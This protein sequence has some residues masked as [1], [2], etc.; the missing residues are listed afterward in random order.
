MDGHNGMLE[1]RLAEIYAQF[2]HMAKGCQLNV[3]GLI[4][5]LVGACNTRGNQW[6][7]V[8]ATGAAVQVGDQVGGCVLR[9]GW[10]R[11]TDGDL[12]CEL[13]EQVRRLIDAHFVDVVGNVMWTHT[14]S[15]ED[16]DPASSG[17]RNRVEACVVDRL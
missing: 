3:G 13:L 15:P 12:I 16:D 11:G 6:H 10:R 9:F 4:A 5:R 17:R 8:V 1:D 2:E 14:C 7:E